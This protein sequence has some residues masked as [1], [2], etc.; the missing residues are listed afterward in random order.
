MNRG[1]YGLNDPDQ[2][3]LHDH[4]NATADKS[5]YMS[6][7][8][9]RDLIKASETTQYD[10]TGRVTFDKQNILDFFFNNT[11]LT[12]DLPKGLCMVKGRRGRIPV[13]LE[14]LLSAC[15]L[16]PEYPALPSTE[17]RGY[18]TWISGGRLIVNNDPFD[19]NYAKYPRVNSGLLP[20]HIDSTDVRL[21]YG[22]TA[23]LSEPASDV[24]NLNPITDVSDWTFT[25]LTPSIVNE[26]D[27]IESTSPT[28]VIPT[29]V[30]K[31]TPNLTAGSKEFR[32]RK[33]VTGSYNWTTAGFSLSFFIKVPALDPE[34]IVSL[35]IILNNVTSTL[36]GSSCTG[37]LNLN[38]K[39]AGFVPSYHGIS[40]LVIPV[41]SEWCRVEMH[42]SENYYA[43]T[44]PEIDIKILPD[45]FRQYEWDTFFSGKTFSIYGMQL[46]SNLYPTS[47]V[48]PQV[49]DPTKRLRYKETVRIPITDPI[50]VVGQLNDV[51]PYLSKRRGTIL[52][53][54]SSP[55]IQAIPLFSLD[56][57]TGQL[58][59]I[60]GGVR[61]SA[62]VQENGTITTGTPELSHR[63]H[64]DGT[65]YVAVSYDL[66]AGTVT[67]M[68]CSYGYSQEA[69]S[70]ETSTVQ[71]TVQDA[72]DL[73]ASGFDFINLS[74]ERPSTSYSNR[75]AIHFNRVFAWDA[76][77]NTKHLENIMKSIALDIKGH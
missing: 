60:G 62:L 51:Y 7:D 69:L 33:T 1:P 57:A 34:R 31:L 65:I 22:L 10:K 58:I 26:E 23:V 42:V 12:M 66:S 32:F 77:I 72:P 63:V 8:H 14:D 55:E 71:L 61:A 45:F 73:L 39:K 54:V 27:F 48:H 18:E 56:Y 9:V 76:P 53:Q 5:G 68:T 29:N 41:N 64:R 6:T 25:N 20:Q 3:F 28:P 50:A 47:F 67:L 36:D 11:A 59:V 30:I 15:R 38:G 46:E 4:E 16:N 17:V 37:I 13:A 24:L 70:V 19:I 52:M 21:P 43:G 75:V 49:S 74:P 44:N 40:G 2:L 35:E